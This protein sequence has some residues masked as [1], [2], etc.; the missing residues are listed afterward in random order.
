LAGISCII[1][2]IMIAFLLPE[3]EDD[4]A[5]WEL[6]AIMIPSVY[7]FGVFALKTFLIVYSRRGISNKEKST[8]CLTCG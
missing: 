3:H 1:I 2:S 4:G 5:N 6:F 8:C 7:F